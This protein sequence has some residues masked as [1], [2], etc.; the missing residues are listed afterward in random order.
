M[1]TN[2]ENNQHEIIACKNCLNKLDKL[3]DQKKDVKLTK[4]DLSFIQ[5]ILKTIKVQKNY[6]WKEV[7]FNKSQKVYLNAVDIDEN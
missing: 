2:K 3:T 6:T 5:K 7:G 4:E 1:K